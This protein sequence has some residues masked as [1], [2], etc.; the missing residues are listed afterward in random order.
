MFQVEKGKI[1][2]LCSDYDLWKYLP[3]NCISLL[4]EKCLS[5][6]FSKFSFNR[7]HT[8]CPW[9]GVQLHKGM[10]LMSL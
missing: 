9:L 2:I 4:F 5:D 3:V 1:K 7:L 6:N 10:F 8:D